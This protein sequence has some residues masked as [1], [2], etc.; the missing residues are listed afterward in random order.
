MLA[1]TILDGDIPIAL[2]K[3]EAD[4]DENGEDTG[5]F[6]P[7]VEFRVLNYSLLPGYEPLRSTLRAGGEAT[8]SLGRKGAFLSEGERRAAQ[9]AMKAAQ[10]I[11]DRLR[12]RDNAGHFIDGRVTMF[13]ET[14]FGGQALHAIGVALADRYVQLSQSAQPNER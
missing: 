6:S 2:A 13:R 4:L 9:E 12:I 3:V 10:A 5:Q 11:D 7:L 14:D 1:I 8:R